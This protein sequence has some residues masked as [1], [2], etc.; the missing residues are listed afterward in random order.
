MLGFARAYGLGRQVV[1]GIGPREVLAAAA[2]AAIGR[3]ITVTLPDGLLALLLAGSAGLAVYALLFAGL[4]VA[5]RR[6][7]ALLMW[8]LGLRR[9]PELGLGR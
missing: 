9:E 7:V 3:A 5:S 8:L 1:P 2:A 6:E 4:K